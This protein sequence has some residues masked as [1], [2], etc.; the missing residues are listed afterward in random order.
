MQMYPSKT[1]KVLFNKDGCLVLLFKKG[2]SRQIDNFTMGYASDTINISNL[3]S[4][5]KTK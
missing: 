2:F 1:K 5:N 3:I 4:T